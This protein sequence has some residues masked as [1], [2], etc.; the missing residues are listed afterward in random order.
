MDK[1]KFISNRTS[2]PTRRVQVSHSH[3]PKPRF[4]QL[5]L[6][7]MHFLLVA[8]LGVFL[9]P[10]RNELLDWVLAREMKREE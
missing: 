7:S 6:Q 9:E 4:F 10:L 2:P 1:A 3:S 8:L 5:S